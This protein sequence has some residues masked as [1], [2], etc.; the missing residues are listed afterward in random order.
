LRNGNKSIF[1]IIPNAA[2]VNYDIFRYFKTK[3][4]DFKSDSTHEN[5]NFLKALAIFSKLQKFASMLIFNFY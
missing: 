4:P 3:K 1:A 5:Q 2:Q